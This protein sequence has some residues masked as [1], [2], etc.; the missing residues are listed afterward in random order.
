MDRNAYRRL[1][2][3][4]CCCCAAVGAP[5]ARASADLKYVSY[6]GTASSRHSADFL[7]GE[8][9][10]LEY[11]EGRLA[12]RVVLYTCRD[13]SAFARKTVSYVDTFAPDFTLEDVS[14][15]MTEGVRSDGKGRFVFFR[16]GQ[17]EQEKS[18]PVP[19]V[20]G[21]V[22]DAGFDEYVRSNW[23]SLMAGKELNM[24]FLVPS[25]LSDIGFQVAHLRSDHWE[26]A[27]TE[28]FRLKL[29]G[30]LGYVLPGID[31][32]YSA[33]DQVLMRYIGLS[34]LRNAS[35]DNFQT[36]ITYHSADRKAADAGLFESARQARLAP[37]T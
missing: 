34:D 14:N 2:M 19:R 4:A 1:A 28:V 29:S 17:G 15:G 7:Y 32:Y 31:V 10:V 36:E 18:N 9:H 6:S 37:C 35:H 21:L 22:V 33:S 30:L 23:Q 27:S 5:V 3:L 20:E 26:G 8:Q 12:Q 13:G 25:R 24:P 16:G 11:R